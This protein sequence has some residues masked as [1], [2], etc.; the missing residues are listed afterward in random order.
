MKRYIATGCL[1]VLALFV[2]TGCYPG[3]GTY[4]A[5]NPAG[6]WW[7]VWH[8]V[9]AIITLIG[10]LFSDTVTIYESYNTGFWYNL[11]FLLGVASPVGGISI[12]R[13]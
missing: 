10:S 3:D 8:G 7:G 6:F 5:D 4:S 12:F 9:I 11:G 1:L 2:L 13:D